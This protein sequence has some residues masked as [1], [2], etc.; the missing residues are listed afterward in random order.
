MRSFFFSYNFYWNPEFH[1]FIIQV[2]VG[3]LEKLNHSMRRGWE[4]TALL[5]EGKLA[6]KKV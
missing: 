1:A 4:A 2:K 5:R 3:L 6:N